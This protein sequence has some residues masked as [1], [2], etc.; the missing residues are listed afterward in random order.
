MSTAFP[1]IPAAT[2]A[3]APAPSLPAPDLPDL[4]ALSSGRWHR[5]LLWL[6]SAMA[7]LAV[8]ALVAR[9][10]DPREIT[11]ANAWDKPLKFAL[12]TLI[13]AVTWSWLIGQ[14]DRGRRIASLAGSGMVVLF[15]AEIVIIA[16]AAA[17]GTTSHF[18]V[19]TPLHAAMWTIMAVSISALW[20]ASLVAA[21]QL[22]RNPLGDRA[23]TI[24]VRSGAVIALVGLALGFLMTG[25]TAGQL[26]DYRG[27]AG[28]HTV[29]LAD[30]GPGLPVLGWSTVA[31]DLRIPHF[32][33]MHALQAIPL[34]L[35]AIELLS[36]RILALR[37]PRLRTALVWIG[38]GAYA[39]VL[40]LVT[41]QALAGQSIVRPDGPT[42]LA[43]A[44]IAV[45]A[46]A[47]ALA[48]ALVARRSARRTAG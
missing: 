22:F 36:R 40:A 28:A 12:S 19:S 27:I 16:G 26:A 46:V 37:D 15:L 42:A 43:G 7:L 18:N 11:G 33:G 35:I 38:T 21:A 32:V 45:A 25:P 2:A 30:G 6:A 29:G 48:A 3:S 5:P 31:G 23:R 44:G 24:A 1:A 13:Y 41:A 39:A 20:V 9:F 4:P 17:A 34:A 47:A 14:L 10:V 8:V